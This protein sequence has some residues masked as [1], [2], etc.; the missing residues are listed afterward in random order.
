M[1]SVN[2]V[3]RKKE[4]KQKKGILFLIMSHSIPS[5]SEQFFVMFL[6]K[7]LANNVTVL[8]SSLTAQSFVRFSI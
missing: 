1:E 2:Y 4:R 5:N 6:R 3:C 8:A 7:T